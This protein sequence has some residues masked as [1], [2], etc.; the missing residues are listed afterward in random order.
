MVGCGNS[1]MGA[2]LYDVGYKQLVSIDISNKVV[3]QMQRQRPEMTFAVQDVTDM[4]GF[5][6][7]ITG[8][9]F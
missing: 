4:S 8:S 1:T 3:S 6:Q 2:D 5:A 9:L 7:A